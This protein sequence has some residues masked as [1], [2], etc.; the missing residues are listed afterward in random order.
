[1]KMPA[2]PIRSFSLT[3]AM[4]LFLSGCGEKST[5]PTPTDPATPTPSTSNSVTEKR[6]RSVPDTPRPYKY[7]L[8][9]G[10]GVCFHKVQDHFGKTLQVT[11]VNG[12]FEIPLKLSSSSVKMEV[13]EEKIQGLRACNVQYQD[14]ENPKKLV[15]VSMDPYTGE[16]RTPR[17]VQIHITSGRAEDFRLADHLIN[18]NKVQLGSIEKQVAAKKAS[19]EKVFSEHQISSFSLKQSPFNGK[20]EVTVSV[21]GI[22]KSNDLTDTESIEFTPEGKLL[23]DDFKK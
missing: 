7:S 16:F 19:I 3:I 11:E 14:P 8:K 22:F 13:P 10:M 2:G 23:S 15:E 6:S 5:P 4:A 12:L 17:P 20:F 18:L 21:A 9:D 1:M